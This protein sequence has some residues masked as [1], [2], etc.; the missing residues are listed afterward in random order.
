MNITLSMLKNLLTR[1]N[2]KTQKGEKKGILTAVL[3]LAPASSAGVGN[4]CPH[5]SAGC[6]ATCLNTAGRAGIL[7]K[8]ENTNAILQARI[9]KTILFYKYRPEF[10]A[11]LESEIQAH[12]KTARKHGLK[13]AIRLNG[14][15][16]IDWFRLA[17]GMINRAADAGAVLY[18]YTKNWR[19][20][21]QYKLGIDSLGKPCR[22]PIHFT[23]SRTENTPEGA[24]YNALGNGINVAAVFR[25]ARSKPL[26]SHLALQGYDYTAQVI[27]GDLDDYRPADIQGVIVGLRAKGKA[28]TDR[29]GF[30]ID[31]E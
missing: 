9:R 26:P 16:D 7:K 2:P 6:I 27:D 4:V 20:A 25:T 18:D 21:L 30:V 8:G 5:A 15:S 24:I 1:S 22:N 12:I 23:V 31:P 10:L 11:Q 29:T 3:H 19:M 13:P 28:R 17:P 14:T